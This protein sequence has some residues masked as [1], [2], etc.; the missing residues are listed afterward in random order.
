MIKVVAAWFVGEDYRL[1]MTERTGVGDG[2][3]NVV[4]FAGGVSGKVSRF[5]V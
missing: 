1:S 2:D 5:W 3:R 4:R